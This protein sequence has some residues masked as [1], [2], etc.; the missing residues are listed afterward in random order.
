MIIIPMSSISSPRRRRNPKGRFLFIFSWIFFSLWAEGPVLAAERGQPGLLKL[1]QR[2]NGA[3]VQQRPQEYSPAE[4]RPLPPPKAPGP[5]LQPP[6]KM[7]KESPRLDQAW[8]LYRRG[9]YRRAIPLFREETQSP[10]RS[11]ALEAKLGLAYCFLQLGER[12]KA[13][14]LLEELAQRKYKTKETLPALLSLLIEEKDFEKARIYLTQMPED[15]QTKWIRS[16]REKEIRRDHSQAMASP[17]SLAIKG[18]IEKHGDGLRECLAKDAFLHAAQ[19][20]VETGEKEGG[21]NVFRRL[22]DCAERDWP[23]RLGIYQS[24]AVLLPPKDG[25]GLIRAE[26][27]RGEGPGDYL[28]QLK[29]LELSLL[30]KELRGLEASSPRVEP[31]ARK[32]LEIE[33]QDPEIEEALAWNYYNRKEN[34]QAEALFSSLNRRFPGNRDYAVGLVYSLLRMG[35]ISEAEESLEKGSFRDEE[36]VGLKVEVYR[37]RAYQAFEEKRFKEAGGYARKVLELDPQNL[38]ARN[39]WAWALVEQGNDEEALAIAQKEQKA[40]GRPVEYL[41]RMKSLEQAVLRKKLANLPLSSPEVESIASRL[42]EID[43]EDLFAQG[44][45]AWFYFHRGQDQAAYRHFSALH[46]KD[47][48]NQDFA[49]GLVYTQLRLGKTQEARSTIEERDFHGEEWRRLKISVYLR[50]AGESYRDGRHGEAEGEAQKVLAIAADHRE[51]QKLLAR[52]RLGQRRYAEALPLLLEENRREP[53]AQKTQEILLLYE[54]MGEEKKGWELAQSL[55]HAE[56]LSLRQI[57]GKFFY[58]RKAPVTAAQTDGRTDTCYYSADKPSIEIGGHLR[59][60]TGDEGLSQLT[61]ISLPIILDHP[62]RIGKN[63][64]FSLIP[65]HLSSGSSPGF[66]YAGKYYRFLNGIPKSH[67][68]ETSLWLVRPELGFQKEGPVHYGFLL[69]T[70]FWNA[71]ISPMPTLSAG[72]SGK[73]WMIRLDQQSVDESILSYAG[74]TDPYGGEKW[75]RV[76]KTGLE[77]ETTFIPDPPYWLHLAAGYHYLWGKAVWSNQSVFGTVSL[78]RTWRLWPGEL[79]LGGFAH[80]KHFQRNTNFFTYGHG[81]YFSPEVFFMIGPTLR[82][83]THPCLTDGIDARVSAGYLYYTTQEAPHY[84]L[85]DDRLDSLNEAARNDATG[86]YR[87]ETQSK[88]GLDGRIRVKKLFLNRIIGS[89]YG[90]INT[91]SGY[92]EWQFGITV[93]YFFES[94][95]NGEEFKHFL[96]RDPPRG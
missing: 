10:R 55:R 5:S 73:S 14:P 32:I 52:S 23:F 36:W 81:G 25:A 1:E 84:P 77:G 44:T 61:E 24:L 75:G 51:A 2:K 60:K 19:K 26:R 70:T 41:G 3:K 45:I 50:S 9:D 29:A 80:A 62:S 42:L 49:L 79:S 7:K 31:L 91:T 67:D 12:P 65:T 48:S 85:F 34:A 66:P 17:D 74:L 89:A 54:K 22:L 21:M 11:R 87:G 92:S 46:Q 82:F 96:R 43:P 37:K 28:A 86:S 15:D 76:L 6:P 71:P 56:D 83:K 95:F 72:I 18:F 64:S 68:L 16:L 63:W 69:G 94:I 93:E 30:R 4:E 8:R 33:P 57:A 40:P 27:Q 53:S 35:K 78:G 39:L 13:M 38:E 20:L 88:L 47:P 58:D 59:H 90:A